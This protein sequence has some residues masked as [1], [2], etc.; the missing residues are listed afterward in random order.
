MPPTSTKEQCFLLGPLQGYITQP[1]E[2]VSSEINY[3][4]HG[5]E[6]MNMEVEGSMALEDIT[7]RLVKT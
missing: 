2:L 1:T 7:R 5:Y 4:Q 6:A 3:I